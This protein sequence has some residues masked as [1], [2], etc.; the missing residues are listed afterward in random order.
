MSIMNAR[1][2]SVQHRRFSQAPKSIISYIYS[3]CVRRRRR[4]GLTY[5]AQQQQQQNVI[6]YR[7]AR[8]SS[9]FHIKN[10]KKVAIRK[11]HACVSGQGEEAN[12]KEKFKASL[13]LVAVRWALTQLNSGS[14]LA[15]KSLRAVRK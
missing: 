9:F 2:R 6:S 4:A 10:A 13:C 14:S 1:W 7:H 12:G 5:V 8:S 15:L 11:S 3:R